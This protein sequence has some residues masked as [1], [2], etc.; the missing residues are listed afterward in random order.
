MP[1][2]SGPLSLAFVITGLEPGGAERAMV[3]LATGL[4]RP[5]FAPRVYSLQPRPEPGRDLLV[6][7]LEQSGVEVRFLDVSSKWGWLG[8]VH[9]LAKVLSAERPD[10]VQTFLLHANVFGAWA[11]HKAGIARVVTGLR[12]AERRGRWRLWL[13]RWASRWAVRHVAVSESVARFARESG[14]LAAER[15][16]VIPNGVDVP[17]FRDATPIDLAELGVPVGRKVV[18]CAGRL[19]EQKGLDWLLEGAPRWLGASP[20]HDLLIVGQGP[21][22]ARLERQA[23]DLGI[24]PRVHFAGWRGEIAGILKSSVLLVLPSAWEGMPNVLLEGMA[25][26][27][28]VVAREVE[29]VVEVLGEGTGARSQRSVADNS[30]DFCDKVVTVL[31]NPEL[32]QR[33]GLENQLRAAENFRWE[34]TIE[35]YAELYRT[36]AR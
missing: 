1:P 18:V 3:R 30:Q 7:E 31:T 17:R 4:P 36:L 25:A 32:G 15:I 19:E 14:G 2:S 16:V 9:R 22:R 24:A 29:G 11:A 35:R 10:L 28:P 20:E 21:E 33:L 34:K 6:D 13:E 23:A 5:E 8:A 26:G 27:L 12:V